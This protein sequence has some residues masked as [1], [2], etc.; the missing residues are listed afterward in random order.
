MKG[1]LNDPGGRFNIGDINPSQF[2]P[3][4]ALYLAF[5]KDTAL[6]ELLSQPINPQEEKLKLDPLDFALTSPDSITVVSL[7]GFLDSII[8][9][10]EPK[11]LQPFVDLIKEFTIPDDLKKT[12]KEIGEHDPDLI[13]TVSKL[14]DALLDPNWRLWSMQFDV[15]VSSQI[16]GQLVAE[17]GI[18]GILYTS[19]FTGKDCLTIFPQNF[20]DTNGSFIQLDDEA[21]AEIK[22]RRL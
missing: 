6:Q 2:P 19:K 17:A 11:K 18:E 4:P 5:D 10:K 13:R 20:D 1:S 8:N 7:S 21:P 22:I 14:V 9:L 16:F 15:P 3:F 12:A